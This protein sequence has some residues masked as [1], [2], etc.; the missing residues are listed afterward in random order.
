V[1][2]VADGGIRH[3]VQARGR[4]G[5]DPRSLAPFSMDGSCA[6]MIRLVIVPDTG[7]ACAEPLTRWAHK[8]SAHDYPSAVFLS[9]LNLYVQYPNEHPSP[10]L[11]RSVHAAEARH[12]R[13]SRPPGRRCVS[14][15]T[16]A[17]R[18]IGPWRV[19]WCAGHVVIQHHVFNQH[20]KPIYY[21]T[22]YVLQIS[23][24]ILVECILQL[25]AELSCG[26][27]CRSWRNNSVSNLVGEFS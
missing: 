12:P 27:V 9:Q 7:G 24:R 5:N 15:T 11:G 2:G 23:A 10:S 16:R 4:T 8:P 14:P 17:T 21:S 22:G 13:F 19:A 6:T 3:L 26:I 25:R 20:S 18:H 1:W